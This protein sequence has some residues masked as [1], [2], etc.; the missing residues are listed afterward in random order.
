MMIVT[1][2]DRVN[3]AYEQLTFWQ[4]VRLH[5]SRDYAGFAYRVELDHVRREYDA[6]RSV[7]RNYQSGWKPLISGRT[8]VHESGRVARMVD[9]EIDAIRGAAIS[10]Y[11]DAPVTDLDINEYSRMEPDD[12][13]RYCTRIEPRSHLSETRHI[14]G[15]PLPCPKH[16]TEDREPRPGDGPDYH[17]DRQAWVERQTRDGAQ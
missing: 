16:S 14:C 17:A 15:Y 10:S 11:E 4:K 3:T 2:S 8:W 7:V 6:L 12:Q 1:A 9:S 13:H 5:L